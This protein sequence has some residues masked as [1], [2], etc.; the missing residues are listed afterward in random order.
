MFAYRIRR[1]KV[2]KI[3]KEIAAQKTCLTRQNLIMAH[4]NIELEKNYR[5]HHINYVS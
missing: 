3:I 1:N 4:N 2:C 5:F